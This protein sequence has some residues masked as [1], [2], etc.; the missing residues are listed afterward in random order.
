MTKSPG[1]QKK[2]SPQND[3]KENLLLTPWLGKAIGEKGSG[4]KLEM[5]NLLLA[6]SDERISFSHGS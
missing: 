4:W 6:D 1:W 2:S 5:S 3:G